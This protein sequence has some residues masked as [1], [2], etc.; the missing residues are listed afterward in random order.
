MFFVPG[1]G[2]PSF[3]AKMGAKLACLHRVKI[4]EAIKMVLILPRQGSFQTMCL[5]MVLFPVSLLL[6][7]CPGTVLGAGFVCDLPLSA[8]LNFFSGPLI[9]EWDAATTFLLRVFPVQDV[10]VKGGYISAG[11]FECAAARA[12][13][14][15]RAPAHYLFTSVANCD[16]MWCGRYNEK[17]YMCVHK[18]ILYASEKAEAALA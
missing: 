12:A 5:G 8:S 9:K 11:V 18:N 17:S 13:G 10:L 1:G 15:K 2:E 16:R 6:I 14:D 4:S 7:G 3:L